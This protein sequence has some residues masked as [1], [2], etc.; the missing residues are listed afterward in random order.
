MTLSATTRPLLPGMALACVVS[1]AAVYAEPLVR[2]LSGGRLTLPIMVI[3]LIVGI[4]LHSLAAR[5]LFEPGLT[6]AVKKLLRW[7]IGLL[8]LRIAFGDILGLGVGTLILFPAFAQLLVRERHQGLCC[9]DSLL[10]V[11][12]HVIHGRQQKHLRVLVLHCG[13]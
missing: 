5:P 13:S 10:G 12:P 11:Q 7:A 9:V 3:A 8:G 6:F 4:A 1:V 2:Q